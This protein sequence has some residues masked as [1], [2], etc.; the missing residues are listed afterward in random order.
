M[1]LQASVQAC[2]CT[3]LRRYVTMKPVW[4][5]AGLFFGGGGFWSSGVRGAGVRVEPYQVA[6]TT[7]GRSHTE[8][9]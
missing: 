5:L 8:L 2:V 1:C 6:L 9:L 7:L 4:A 3:F